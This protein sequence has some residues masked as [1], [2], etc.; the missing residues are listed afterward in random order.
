MTNTFTTAC[1]ILKNII[2]CFNVILKWRDNTCE[3][4][5][6]GQVSQN[7]HARKELR[8]LA[9]QSDLKKAHRVISKFE[10]GSLSLNN[11]NIYPV[12]QK[13]NRVKQEKGKILLH[14]KGAAFEGQ[15]SVAQK[16]CRVLLPRKWQGLLHRK[17]AEKLKKGAKGE[18]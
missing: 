1:A 15:G 9:G 3:S 4:T 12:G 7:F 2:I 10:A 6:P 5:Y 18:D 8:V 16:K 17:R 11:Y 13:K 14:R